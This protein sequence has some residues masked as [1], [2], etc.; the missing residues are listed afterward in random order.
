MQGRLRRLPLIALLLL[1]AACGSSTRAN[2]DRPPAPIAPQET[3]RLS[4]TVS[5][6]SYRLAVPS[7]SARLRVGA[8]RHSA[9]N[10]LLQ[11]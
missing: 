11:P 1:L 7:A 8:Q 2:V 9:Q 4:V 5:R 6:G 3:S 10:D